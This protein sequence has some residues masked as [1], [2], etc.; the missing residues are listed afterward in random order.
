MQDTV[1]QVNKLL[2][3][4][5]KQFDSVQTNALL[6]K[7]SAF[8]STIIDSNFA[9]GGRWDGSGF[10]LFS[11]G[12]QKWTP[13]AK[14]TVK[15]YQRLGYDTKPTLYRTGRLKAGI[16]IQPQGKNSIVLSNNV[17][18][19]SRHQFGDGFTT[20]PRPFFTL[21]Q[22]DLQEIAD[23]IREYYAGHL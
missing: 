7:I 13:L 20:P 14:N 11:G 8:I 15:A 22:Q 18:Y 2:N 4:V 5:H 10:G 6:T 21:N 3:D 16:D 12:S 9:Q 17:E 1:K 19:A 23:Y